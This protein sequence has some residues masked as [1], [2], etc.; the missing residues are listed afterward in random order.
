MNRTNPFEQKLSAALE[1]VPSLKPGQ[2]LLVALSG[3]ADSCALLLGLLH[4]PHYP[5]VVAHYDHDLRASSEK[6][7]FF[8]QDLA[9]HF[10]IPFYWQRSSRSTTP[11]FQHWS[12][13]EAAR[14]E[15]MAFLRHILQ[16]ASADWIVLGHTADDQV[17]TVLLRLLTGAG[18]EGLKG[19]PCWDDQRKLFH[20]L[21]GHWRRETEAYCRANGIGYLTDESNKDPAF[22]RN[23]LRLEI[24]PA[25]LWR[26]PGAKA[27]IM[28]TSQILAEE[29]RYLCSQAKRTSSLW[30]EEGG[31]LIL[32][33]GVTSLPLAIRRRVIQAALYRKKNKASF[34]EV[35]TIGELFDKQVGRQIQLSDGLMA[36]RVYAGVQIGPQDSGENYKPVL[37]VD[38]PATLLLPDGRRLRFEF[39]DPSFTHPTP[40]AHCIDPKQTSHFIVRYW[41]PGDR[42]W[43]FGAPGAKKLQDFFVDRKV[44]RLVRHRIPL[45]LCGEEI[46]C[47]V[48]FTIGEKFRLGPNSTSCLRIQFEKETGD[49]GND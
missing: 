2:R 29:N 21:L 18:S 38:P 28:R 7:R 6:D 47:L 30:Q 32:K 35:K 26:F 31:N 37:E 34:A 46:A 13:E 9:N 17:E 43:P 19:I 42:F 16:T 22:L 25:I 12:P 49:E 5:L 8:C 23:A 20:P 41:K 10:Q 11:R 33:K 14:M 3:G 48:G 24:L 27:A 44:A 15:R 36:L 40:G 1:Q 45:I 4:F 39:V